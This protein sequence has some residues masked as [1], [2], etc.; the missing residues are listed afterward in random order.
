MSE[1]LDLTQTQVPPESLDA[2]EQAPATPH[3]VLPSALSE[4]QDLQLQFEAQTPPHPV[5]DDQGFERRAYDV[6]DGVSMIFRGREEL[7]TFAESDGDRRVTRGV[8]GIEERPEHT[9]KDLY[10]DWTM[11][12]TRGEPN[13]DVFERAAEEGS[14]SIELVASSSPTGLIN[15]ALALIELGYGDEAVKAKLGH[16]KTALHEGAVTDDIIKLYD[17][18]FVASTVDNESLN[19]LGYQ[20]NEGAPGHVDQDAPMI[21]ARSLAGDPVATSLIEKKQAKLAALE[22]VEDD[23]LRSHEGLTDDDAELKHPGER[24]SEEELEIMGDAHFVAVHTTVANPAEVAPGMRVMRP[25]SE[26]NKDDPNRSDRSTLHWSLNHP[27]QSHIQGN[28]IGRPYTIV[29]PLEEL[30]RINGA[31]GV[32]YGVDTYFVT[33]PGEGMILPEDAV[34]I[35]THQ[36]SN[37]PAIQVDGTSIELKV[38]NYAAEDVGALVDYFTANYLKKFADRGWDETQARYAAKKTVGEMIAGSEWSLYN[39]LPKL[40]LSDEE[41]QT[42]Q[43]HDY[44][45]SVRTQGILRAFHKQGVDIDDLARRVAA[46]ESAA[47][48]EVIERLAQLG[49]DIIEDGTIADYPELHDELG[50]AM[51]IR[52][53]QDTIEGFGAKVVQSDGMSAYILDPEFQATERAVA[54]RIGFRT[55]LH[56]YH[57]ES[58]AEAVIP[59]QLQKA[60]VSVPIPADLQTEDGPSRAKGD[61]DWTEFDAEPIMSAMTGPRVPWPIRRRL[62]A[63]GLMSYGHKEQTFDDSGWF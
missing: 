57:P 61:F 48:E 44:E 41:K 2:P 27:V 52:V 7:P 37:R 29:A 62:V 35:H 32:L 12:V 53:T 40:T 28:F 59:E 1:E 21:V 8:V 22:E 25:S 5:V 26:Y 36:D 39:D 54:K 63:R 31:P 50:E 30:T 17:D 6:A 33:N 51:R 55:G 42:M 49:D 46:R 13:E 43:P 20:V 24:L 9:S 34:V 58:S 10:G 19:M 14:D 16:M 11:Q 45:I 18:I 4:L 47:Y 60:T 56:Q 23:R 15:A 38:G 3:E